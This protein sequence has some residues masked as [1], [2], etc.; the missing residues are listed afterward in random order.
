[1]EKGERKGI[2]SRLR[3]AASREEGRRRGK[4]LYFTLAPSCFDPQEGEKGKGRGEETLEESDAGNH[5]KA[6]REEGRR[7]GGLKFHNV[8]P[9]ITAETGKK[10]GKRKA[11]GGQKGGAREKKGG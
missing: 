7:K 1:L 9:F 8:Y 5:L 6:E 10:G 2:L 3:L 4:A 11:R